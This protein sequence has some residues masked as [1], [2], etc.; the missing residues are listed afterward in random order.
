MLHRTSRGRP[1][2]APYIR[3][4]NSKKTLKYQVF[5]YPVPEWRRKFSEIFLK[6]PVS[7]IVPKNVEGGPF[8]LF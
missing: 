1:K 6:T 3:L 5:S 7:R 2:S 4:K 8:G